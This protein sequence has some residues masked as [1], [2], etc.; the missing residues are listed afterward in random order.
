[1]YHTCYDLFI[2]VAKTLK[3]LR[4]HWPNETNPS[5]RIF[6]SGSQRSREC[7]DTTAEGAIF[8]CYGFVPLCGVGFSLRSMRLHRLSSVQCRYLCMCLRGVYTQQDS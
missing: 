2:D 3:F 6:D 7:A 5:S 4:S 8:H 1:M